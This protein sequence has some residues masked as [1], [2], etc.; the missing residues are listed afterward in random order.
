M[1]TGYSTASL[2]PRRRTRKFKQDR[3]NVS[4]W[5][6]AKTEDIPEIFLEED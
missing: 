3:T 5:S 4:S 6:K 2:E 1:T